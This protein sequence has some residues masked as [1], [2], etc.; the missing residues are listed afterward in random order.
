MTRRTQVHLFYSLVLMSGLTLSACSNL[1]AENG[2]LSDSDVAAIRALD[3]QYVYGWL[4][5][6]TSGV[7]NTLD[8]QAV[9]MPA[10]IKPIMGIEEIRQFWWPNDGSRTIVT[11]YSMEVAEVGGTG[12]FAYSRGSA[13]LTFV[14]EKDGERTE[15]SNSTMYLTVYRQQDDGAWRILRR[16][17]AQL[18]D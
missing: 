2:S 12:D 3:D 16:M 7:L 15:Q 5:D 17:W 14:Y 13:D 6:D 18:P 4:Q 1:R 9:L 8:D 10:G 11:D